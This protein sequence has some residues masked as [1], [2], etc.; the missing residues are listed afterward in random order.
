MSAY[1]TSFLRPGTRIT[2]PATA[3]PVGD[4]MSELG[5]AYEEAGDGLLRGGHP[6]EAAEKY[7][8]ARCVFE[9]V[10]TKNPCDRLAVTHLRQLK[11]RIG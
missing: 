4:W 6:L 11:E 7:A 10:A 1:Q 5:L 2:A 8:A 3:E 9:R